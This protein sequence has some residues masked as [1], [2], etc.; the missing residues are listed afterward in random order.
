MILLLGQSNVQPANMPSN[1][2]PLISWVKAGELHEPIDIYQPGFADD[3]ILTDATGP[4]V[5]ALHV[6]GDSMYPEYREGDIVIIDPGI[7]PVSGDDAIVKV[8]DEVTFKQVHFYL[9]KIR[10]I[11]LNRDKYEPVEISREDG[12][13]VQIIGKVIELKRRK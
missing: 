12:F 10:L 3:W 1:R 9:D 7:E 2:V 5:F 11:P 6:V 13:K 8:N 4:N